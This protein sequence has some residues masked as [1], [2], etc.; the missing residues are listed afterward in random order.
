MKRDAALHL[1][2]DLSFAAGRQVMYN[3]TQP[4]GYAAEPC[5]TVNY[6]SC[7]DGEVLFDQLVMK[8]QEQVPPPDYSPDTTTLKP[9][10][11]AAVV[12]VIHGTLR[13]PN[14]TH[15]PR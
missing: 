14:H 10:R 11:P 1:L 3:G 6:V 8:P 15:D 5:E 4:A 12:V 9:N 7:H 2:D 13:L